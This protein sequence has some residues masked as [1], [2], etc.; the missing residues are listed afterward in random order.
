M[1]PPLLEPYRPFVFS[2]D[3]TNLSKLNSAYTLLKLHFNI[4]LCV[5]LYLTSP[6]SISLTD[7]YLTFMS[8]RSH[9]FYAQ[10]IFC[11]SVLALLC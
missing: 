11:S 3:P 5:T 10:S 1:C 6:V 2:Q 7:Q 9:A 8:L 4:T